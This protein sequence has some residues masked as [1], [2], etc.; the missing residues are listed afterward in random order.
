MRENNGCR[1]Y[2]RDTSADFI[3]SEVFILVDIRHCFLF[4]KAI[5]VNIHFPERS[6]S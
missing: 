4:S 6:A 3:E 5:A 2:G 1:L